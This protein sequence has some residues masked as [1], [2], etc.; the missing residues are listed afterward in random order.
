MGEGSGINR[1]KNTRIT[2]IIRSWRNT[3]T[4]TK[5]IILG[6]VMILLVL[7]VLAF[8][9]GTKEKVNTSDPDI[10]P[11]SE[12]AS[13]GD[14]DLSQVKTDTDRSEDQPWTV[15]EDET[16]QIKIEILTKGYTGAFVEDG[17]NE[18]VEE[19][20]ALRFTNQG[21]R[22]IQYAEYVFGIN[23]EAVS[24]KLTD[25][26]SKESCV[27]LEMN[28][29]TYRKSDVLQLTTR[30]VAT[31]DALPSAQDQ[32]LVVD[33]SDN[34]LTLM[35]LTEKDL[36]NARVFYKNYD[37][38]LECYLGGITYSGTAE[39]IPAGES[40]TVAPQQ[41]TSGSSVLMGSQIESEE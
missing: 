22:P 9:H 11:A 25:L 5:V 29:R 35:N 39:R 17:S 41:Y 3:G 27:V 24:F 30:V 36:I 31:V 16:Y 15:I 33:N 40:I 38:E 14:S 23:D 1:K 18:E 20:L 2:E 37:E 13:Q 26:P 12:Y 21:D 32:L 19:V 6:A 10:K 28:R 7:I 8:S 4:K 34:T